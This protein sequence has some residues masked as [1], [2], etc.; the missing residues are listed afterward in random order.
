MKFPNG[1]VVEYNYRK[2]PLLGGE[3]VSN[4]GTVI[5]ETVVGSDSAYI[6]RPLDCSAAVHVREGG[7]YLLK[8][9]A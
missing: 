6:I 3:I 7:V 9:A 4:V 5:G 2:H 8:G 1:S